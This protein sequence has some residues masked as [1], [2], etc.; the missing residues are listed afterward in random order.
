[1]T[2]EFRPDCYTKNCRECL[3][4]SQ[5]TKDE[6]DKELKTILP[7]WCGVCFGPMAVP[8]GTN[9]AVCLICGFRTEEK[10]KK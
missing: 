9:E 2:K 3:F 8:I 4:L 5:C 7:S 1:M 10:V 6:P